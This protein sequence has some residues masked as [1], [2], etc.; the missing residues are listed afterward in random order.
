MYMPKISPIH[1]QCVPNS[2]P[3]CIH[4]MAT[5]FFYLQLRA[6]FVPITFPLRAQYVPA[7]NQP[8]QKRTTPFLR[9]YGSMEYPHAI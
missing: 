4:R 8:S 6:Q 5:V 3:M 2:C 1:T 9:G 7:E